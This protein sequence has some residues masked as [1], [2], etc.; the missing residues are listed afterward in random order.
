MLYVFRVDPSSVVTGSPF[1][2]STEDFKKGIEFESV[3]KNV[4]EV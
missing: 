1:S 4:F 3:V 2:P